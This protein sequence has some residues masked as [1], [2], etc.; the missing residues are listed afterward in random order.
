MPATSFLGQ[1]C[2]A[3]VKYS[4]SGKYSDLVPS[5][6]YHLF[7]SA[8][9]MLKSGFF[10]VQVLPKILEKESSITKVPLYKQKKIIKVLLTLQDR[11][12]D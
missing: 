7:P 5:A 3:T 9:K 8:K 10:A 4:A 12:L 11:I 6:V 1:E 2:N